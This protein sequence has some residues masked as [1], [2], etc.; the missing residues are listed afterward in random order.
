M[1]YLLIRQARSM[2]QPPRRMKTNPMSPTKRVKAKPIRKRPKATRVRL[3][4][5]RARNPM[6]HRS[7]MAP[8]SSMASG[9]TA[10]VFFPA[11]VTLLSAMM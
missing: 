6:T 4:F 10:M 3:R 9:A 7:R 11:L 2:S 8:P 1:P 5:H